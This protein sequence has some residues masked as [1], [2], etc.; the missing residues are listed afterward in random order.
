MKIKIKR[1]DK[2]LPLP[3]YKTNG[4]AAFDVYARETVRIDAHSVKLI[5][6]NV[7]LELPKGCWTMVAARSSTHKKG[8]MAAN[9]VGI[10]DRDYC[11]EEDEYHFAALNFTE[12][13]VVIERGTRIAQMM[14]FHYERAE[15]EEV[16][17]FA[18]N[19]SR[20][21]FGSTGER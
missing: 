8:I 6:L 4:A 19:T 17:S 18:H 3:V 7:I 16:D 21:G 1:V 12:R 14:I 13:E 9:G 11:G 15:F 20:G 5:P 10:G 2:S